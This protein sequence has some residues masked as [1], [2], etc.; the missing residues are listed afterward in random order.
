MIGAAPLRYPHHPCPR[1]AELGLGL[2]PGFRLLAV[3]VQNYWP[4][5][6]NGGRWRREHFRVSQTVRAVAV[7]V[8]VPVSLVSECAEFES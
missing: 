5:V 7:C 8:P 1:D 6:R 3:F 4:K 2:F